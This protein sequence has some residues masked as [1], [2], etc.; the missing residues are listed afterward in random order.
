MK[1]G[2]AVLLKKRYRTGDLSEKSLQKNPWQTEI[3]PLS[4]FGTKTSVDNFMDF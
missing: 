3:I 1:A 2:K 4:G